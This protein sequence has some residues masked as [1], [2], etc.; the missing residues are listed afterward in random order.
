MTIDHVARTV[1]ARVAPDEIEHYPAVRDEYFIRGRANRAQ[2]NPL[3]FGE[4]VVGAVTGIVLTVLHGLVVESITDAARPWW[5]RAWRWVAQRL[6]LTRSARV[7]ADTTLRTVPQREI[8]ALLTSVTRQ[9]T[10]A[11]LPPDQAERLAHAIVD[12]I[13]ASQQDSGRADVSF[14]D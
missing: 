8:P 4:I 7:E 6:R 9:A 11:G 5:N 10:E 14:T 3:G 13:T 2:D 12:T 1:V